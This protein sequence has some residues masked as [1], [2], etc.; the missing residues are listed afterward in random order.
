VP[1]AS[2]YAPDPRHLVLGPAHHDEVRAAAFPAPTL[3]WRDDRAAAEVGLASLTDDEWLAHF[4]RFA[5]LP[6]NLPAPLAL[7]YHGHQFGSYNPGLG[8]G[9]GF[10]FAQLRD[11]RGALRDLGTKGSGTTPYSRGFD[12][13]LTLQGAVREILAAS[14]LAALGVPTCRILSVVET[15]EALVRQDEP[16]PTRGA[17]MVRLSAS[18]VRFGTFQRLAHLGERH[19]LRRLVMYVLETYLPHLDPGD[20]PAATL[21]GHEVW[22]HADL[23]ARYLAAGFVHG[24]LNTDNL[25]VTG[26]SFDYGPWRFAPTWDEAFTA[27]Y[28]DT[29]GY[30]ALGRQ[31]EA[32]ARN[33]GHLADALAP[34]S[35]RAALQAALAMFPA[36]FAAARVAAMVRRLGL[37]LGPRSP[38]LVD[39]LLDFAARSRIGWD[40]LCFDLRGGDLDRAAAGPAAALYRSEAFAPVVALLAAHVAAPGALAH[41]YWSRPAPCAM[42]IDEVRALWAAIAERDDWAPLHA[43]L[44]EIRLLEA[45][46]AG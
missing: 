14:Q 39:A 32:F 5:P 18:H 28:F 23:V 36:A 13:R 24:V 19:E 7:R 12:G 26:E 15:G 27:A 4:G 1:V 16:S 9:R 21:L 37:V 31:P 11:H 46:M 29:G 41:P 38:A 10:L 35:S 34:S 45:A 44:A 25:E 43:K 8:D 22:A 20:D 33:L 6:D 3:R 30:Y 42:L 40:R 2:T 17:V